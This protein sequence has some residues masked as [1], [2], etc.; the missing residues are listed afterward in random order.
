MSRAPRGARPDR[1]EQGPDAAAP[2]AADDRAGIRDRAVVG[3]FW[4]AAQKW[5]VRVS[6][7]LA[8]VLLGRLLS[9]Q[10]FGVVALAMAVVSVL[11]VVSDAGFTPWLIQRRE[12]SATATSTAFWI[13]TA[14]GTVLAVGLAALAVPVADAFDSPELRLILPVLAVTLVVMG[15]SGVPAALL[16]REMRF[17]D[18]AVRQVL[19]TVVSIVVAVALAFAGAG[20][21]ALVAQTLVRVGVACVVLWVTSDFRPRFV[22]D[23]GDAREMVGYGTKSLGVTLGTAARQSGEP[24]LVGAVLGTVSLGYWTVAGRLASTVVDLC[25]AAMSSV[26][27]PVFSELQDQP[28]R[29]ARTYG[30]MM[31]V[32]GLVLVPVM[33][34]MSLASADVVPLLFGEQWRVSATVASVLAATWLFMGLV[35][36]QRGL[37]IGTGRA[38]RELTLTTVALVGQLGLVVALGTWGL[39]AVAAGL[40]V[41]GALV[42]VGRSV[43]IGRDL[44]IGPGAY[45]QLLALFLASG[46]AAGAVL[47]VVVPAGLTGA[48]RVAVVALLGGAVFAAAAW[49][50]ARPTVRDLVG[51]VRGALARRRGRPAPAVPAGGTVGG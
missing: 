9:P 10:E 30:R 26:A 50:L 8:F 24:F 51:S 33:T 21:W 32:G 2:P 40:S 43:V 35:N 28:A 31:S 34:A 16:Q 20:V 48:A 47:L 37:L 14:L 29:L 3:V 12:L 15:L 11:G 39:T 45:S 44:G 25:S 19:A 49:L 17:K 46:L 7:L 38:G 13:S 42:L 23:R 18:L 4:A 5:L 6:S 27:G 41:W 22:L 1:A 36:L